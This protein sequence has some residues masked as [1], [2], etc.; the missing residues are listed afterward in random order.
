MGKI[1]IKRPALLGDIVRYGIFLESLYLLLAFFYPQRE[2]L[3]W[4][5]GYALFLGC[6]ALICGIYARIAFFQVGKKLMGAIIFFFLL[7]SLTLFSVL[8][9]GSPDIYYYAAEARV[10]THYG[11]NPYLVSP[12]TFSNDIL[13]PH[14]EPFAASFPSIYGPLWMFLSFLPTWL[15]GNSI[16]VL[17]YAF[18][19]IGIFFSVA[20]SIIVFNIARHFLPERRWQ[21]FFLYSWNPFFLIEY[22]NNAHND[23]VM[24]FFLLCAVYALVRKKYVWA[25]PI[26]TLSALVKYQVFILF[27]FFVLFLWKNIAGSRMRLFASSA[28][29][30]FALIFLLFFP[31]WAGWKIFTP[32]LTL[33]TYY[34]SVYSVVPAFLA[35]H[36]GLLKDTVVNIVFGVFFFVFILWL[37]RFWERPTT[38]MLLKVFSWVPAAFFVLCI[39]WLVPWYFVLPLNFFIFLSHKKWYLAMSILMTILP[40]LQTIFIHL[41]FLLVGTFLVLANT[42]VYFF[43]KMFFHSPRFQ[44]RY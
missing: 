1:I 33:Q 22:S 6:A 11:R 25:I 14:I 34:Y 12:A 21:I 30:S 2:I 3:P 36:F 31:F 23:V 37:R 20:S 19:F 32:L 41:N 8:P 39:I 29:M 13:L 10:F 44:E 27:P 43:M 17:L 16:I 24:M 7:F 9:L 42:L 28:I 38:E 26:L 15:F 4:Y 18:K 35:M 40:F 5:A